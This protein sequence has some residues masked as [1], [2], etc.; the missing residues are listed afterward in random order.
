MAVLE[1]GTPPYA[2]WR[3]SATMGPAA[4]RDMGPRHFPTHFHPSAVAATS[5][6]TLLELIMFLLCYAQVF[7]DTSRL[8]PLQ[9]LKSDLASSSELR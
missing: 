8:I 3:V 1:V 6:V 4:E 5:A 7:F 2:S 9:T